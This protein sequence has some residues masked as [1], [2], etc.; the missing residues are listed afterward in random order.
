[1]AGLRALERIVKIRWRKEAHEQRQLCS[2]WR[3]D[4][5]GPERMVEE[6]HIVKVGE[7]RR[8]LFSTRL[9][10]LGNRFHRVGDRSLFKLVD[11]NAFAAHEPI[12]KP[13]LGKYRPTG[14]VKVDERGV[15]RLIS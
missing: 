8:L 5:D 10:H 3:E 6:K 9:R 15:A 14:I 2:G 13:Q 7:F 1:M 11:F 12:A 4:E